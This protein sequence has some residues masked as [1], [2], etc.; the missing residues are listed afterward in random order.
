MVQRG[1][2]NGGGEEVGVGNTELIKGL[3]ITAVAY[4][5]ILSAISPRLRDLVHKGHY[6]Y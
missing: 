5:Y 4:A 6:L 2:D 1:W 3:T